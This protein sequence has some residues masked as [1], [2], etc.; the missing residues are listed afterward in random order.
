M[1][2]E[3]ANGDTE[4]MRLAAAGDRAAF[5]QIVDRHAPALLR[6]ARAIAADEPAAEDAVQDGLLGAWR[7]AA[8]FRGDATVRSW[9]LA[10]VRNAVHRQHR[11]R[12]AEP[13]V[14]EPLEELGVAAGWG[15]ETPETIAIERQSRARLASAIDHLAADDREI[16]LL[17]D[18]EGLPGAQVASILGTGLATM[19]TRLHRARLRLAATMRQ[20]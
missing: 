18:V 10:I 12:A 2:D 8:S 16:L 9:L 3:N 15:Q 20:R 19:K 5:D 14:F 17:R 1:S 11:R 4:L 6:F 7:S 13:A